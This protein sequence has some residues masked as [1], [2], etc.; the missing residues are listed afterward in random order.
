MGT[1]RKHN[2]AREAL[3]R[4]TAAEAG[5]ILMDLSFRPIAVDRGATSILAALSH[6]RRWPDN[7]DPGHPEAT[8]REIQ[9]L[10]RHAEPDG[11]ESMKFRFHLGSFTYTGHTYL[12]EQSAGRDKLMVFHLRRDLIEGDRLAQVASRYHLTDREQEALRGIAM[13]LTN[14]ELALRMNIAP[15]TVKTFLRLVMVKMGVAR[16]TGVVAKL[17][18]HL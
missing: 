2:S 16:R 3:A 17:L 14:K 1:G 4:Q 18:E 11:P 12:V 5:V 7:V 15:N 10:M 9:E 6:E 8:S 13:G